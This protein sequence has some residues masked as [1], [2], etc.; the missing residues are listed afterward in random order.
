MRATAPVAITRRRVRRCRKS[1][2]LLPDASHA[3][4]DYTSAHAAC[5]SRIW[6]QM[7]TNVSDG[8][9]IPILCLTMRNRCANLSVQRIPGCATKAAWARSAARPNPHRGRYDANRHSEN[10]S[11]QRAGTG[12][13]GQFAVA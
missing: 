3:R 10:T 12:E 1:S 4:G 9:V 13:R 2:G 6:P 11:R 5:A 7:R 8:A